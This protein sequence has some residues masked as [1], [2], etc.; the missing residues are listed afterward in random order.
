M[1]ILGTSQGSVGT[2]PTGGAKASRWRWAIQVQDRSCGCHLPR[3][4]TFVFATSCR[5]LIIYLYNL[6]HPRSG[7][8]GATHQHLCPLLPTLEP[9]PQWDSVRWWALWEAIGDR[10]PSGVGSGAQGA[11]S[12]VRRVGTHKETGSPHLTPTRP[13]LT[14]TSRLHTARHRGCCG[15]GTR[16]AVV[17]YSSPKDQRPGTLCGPRRLRRA[18]GVFRHGSQTLRRRGHP[19][20]TPAAPRRRAGHL[21]AARDAAGAAGLAVAAAP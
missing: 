4:R 8:E 17:C 2:A 6:G 7:M 13:P 21:V 16:S 1:Q 12:R 11:P 15:W 18:W 10:E 20:W 3:G 14:W 5:K 9:N 19:S